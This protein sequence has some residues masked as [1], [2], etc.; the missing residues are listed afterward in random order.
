MGGG[1]GFK[2]ACGAGMIT[3][4][5]PLPRPSHMIP[6]TTPCMG[7]GLP[8]S[9][10][11]APIACL[12]ACTHS[13]ERLKKGKTHLAGCSPCD[14][15]AEEGGRRT[16]GDEAASHSPFRHGPH[17]SPDPLQVSVGGAHNHPLGVLGLQRV[18]ARPWC[19]DIFSKQRSTQRDKREEA[20]GKKKIRRPLTFKACLQGAGRSRFKMCPTGLRA[21]HMRVCAHAWSAKPPPHQ[22]TLLVLDALFGRLC[23]PP[24]LPLQHQPPLSFLCACTRSLRLR[25]QPTLNNLSLP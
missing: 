8:S 5:Q 25:H 14:Q 7:E 10:S 18:R 21:Q 17:P 11:R 19:D 23:P 16:G 2:G 24:P 12:S 4:L 1:G 20:V 13:F 6:A 22:A 9:S 15:G 3:W